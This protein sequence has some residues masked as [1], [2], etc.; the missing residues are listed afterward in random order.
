MTPSRN[1]GKKKSKLRDY[2]HL[3]LTEEEKEALAAAAHS[4]EQHPIVTAILGC[5]LV[6]H[7]LDSLLRA[8][9]KKRDDDTWREL[10]SETGPLRSFSAKIAIGHVLGV[11]KDKIQHDL[12][13]VRVIRNAFA[14]SKKLLDFNDPL[15]VPEILSAHLLPKKFKLSLQRKVSSQMAKASFIVIC[16]KLQTAFLRTATNALKAKS[17][18]AQRRATKKSITN[19]LLGNPFRAPPRVGFLHAGNPE[20]NSLL[21]PPGQSGN[22]NPSTPKGYVNALLPFLDDKKK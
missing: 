10:Q 15:I 16:L 6:E 12:N 17:R 14:H 5:T 11:Y 22:P 8:K 9:F 7:E 19:A 20:L 2:S 21:S 18:Q 1:R 13:V 3:A 4:I